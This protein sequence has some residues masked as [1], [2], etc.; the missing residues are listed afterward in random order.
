MRAAV[1]VA[2]VAL[3]SFAPVD[4]K[5]PYCDGDGIMPI[6]TKVVRPFSFV[7]TE[8]ANNARSGGWR[9]FSW[10]LMDLM[11]EVLS[12]ADDPR[13]GANWTCTGY[14]VVEFANNADMIAAIKDQSAVRMGI[15]ATSITR[16]REGT[17]DF[18]QP[19]YDSEQAIMT[20][21]DV[22]TEKSIEGMV[23]A[24]LEPTFIQTIAMVMV[25]AILAGSMVWAWETFWPASNKRRFVSNRVCP[26]VP[27]AISWAFGVLLKFG[28]GKPYGSVSKVIAGALAV[29][30]A[31]TFIMLTA[32]TTVNMSNQ[33]RRN[34][35]ET[36]ADLPGHIVGT[37]N[38]TTS[39]LYLAQHGV[40]INVRTYPDVDSMMQGFVDR[41]VNAVVYDYPILVF[42][43]NARRRDFGDTDIKIVDS[44]DPQKYGMVLPH[45]DDV[46]AEIVNY[47][48]LT[49]MNS[50]DYISIFNRYFQNNES[51]PSL[52]SAFEKMESSL[53]IMLWIVLFIVAIFL[54]CCLWSWGESVRH[55]RVADRKRRSDTGGGEEDGDGGSGSTI[56]DGTMGTVRYYT[57]ALRDK[58]HWTTEVARHK[59]HVDAAVDVRDADLDYYNMGT[60]AR[61]EGILMALV[62]KRIGNRSVSFVGGGR[63]ASAD[64]D[65]ESKVDG[66]EAGADAVAVEMVEAHTL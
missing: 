28:S 6:G 30:S 8:A 43:A 5:L 54:F 26:G 18:S 2:T 42:F 22:S 55:A 1:I 63:G 64:A 16:S 58:R 27:D 39:Q 9:G 7:D 21:D 32:A 17:V 20:R 47:A 31:F 57:R 44:F 37:A 59:A 36:F 4:A 49:V 3:L 53:F 23:S 29:A 19:F 15:A 13:I 40:D 38:A 52:A 50:P 62:E 33:A 45:N 14:R 12:D 56:D 10:D 61:I 66:T 35:I 41:E 65:A 51:D 11:F 48:L 24:L 60:L 46:L 34:V 25:L